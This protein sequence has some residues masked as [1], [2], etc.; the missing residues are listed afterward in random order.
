VNYKIG[1][2]VTINFINL[3][4]EVIEILPCGKLVL[5]TVIGFRYTLSPE[6]IRPYNSEDF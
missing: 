6:K 5:E 4:A 2:I 3:D 1:D